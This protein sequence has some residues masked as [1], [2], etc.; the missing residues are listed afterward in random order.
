MIQLE[1]QIE[2]YIT[3]FMEW[4][5]PRGFSFRITP[6]TDSKAALGR[7]MI[8]I[9]D[10]EVKVANLSWR[11]LTMACSWRTWVYIPCDMDTTVWNLC[12]IF[13]SHY[14]W[15]MKEFLIVRSGRWKKSFLGHF[16]AVQECCSCLPSYHSHTQ[17]TF[18]TCSARWFWCISF[19]HKMTWCWGGCTRWWGYKLLLSCQHTTFVPPSTLQRMSPFFNCKAF[20]PRVCGVPFLLWWTV[21]QLFIFLLCCPEN[22]WGDKN[23]VSNIFH[24]PLL[25]AELFYG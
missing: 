6:I 1:A 15:I 4:T 21:P 3:V 23:F 2:P 13:L 8:W 25:A 5:C 22:S 20:W 24:F 18:V 14:I 17:N 9:L 12:V 11:W 16:H 19:I 10:V 7:P